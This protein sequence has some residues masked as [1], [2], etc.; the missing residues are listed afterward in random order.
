MPD[1]VILS[2]FQKYD[3]VRST[4]AHEHMLNMNETLGACRFSRILSLQDGSKTMNA[5]E[6]KMLA[7]DLGMREDAR[8]CAIK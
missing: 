6:L 3:N 5:Y 2:H 7:Y 4:R 8:G 1:V